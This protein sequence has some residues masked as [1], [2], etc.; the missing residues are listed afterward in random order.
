MSHTALQRVI[1]RML[2]DPQLVSRVFANPASALANEDITEEEG[3]WLVQTDRRAYDVDTLRRARTLTALVEEYPVSCQ[4]WVTQAGTTDALELF[5]SKS[6]FHDCVQS[7]GSL[8]L[9]FGDYLLGA[10]LVR[11]CPELRAFTTLEQHIAMLRRAKPIKKVSNTLCLA[12]RTAVFSL[13]EGA[14]FNYQI[15]LDALNQHPEGLVA[16]AL[17]SKTT[18]GTIPT[19]GTEWVLAS[20]T[21]TINLEILPDALAELLI[22]LP[23][24]RSLLEQRASSLGA[25]ADEAR[26][27]ITELIDDGVIY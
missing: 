5:F 21:G 25:T 1:V 13:P 16:G 17:K 24:E 4:S 12:S 22:A 26:E 20:N 7:R 18:Q 8:A 14:I 6:E 15:I 2:Y 3:N 27:I 19:K 9:A 10:D 23:L 11:L